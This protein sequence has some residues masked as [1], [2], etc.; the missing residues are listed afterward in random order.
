MTQDRPD[1][2][3]AAAARDP[4]AHDVRANDRSYPSPPHENQPNEHRP[5]EH[6]PDE[7]PPAEN[8]PNVHRPAENQPNEHRPAENPPAEHP[9]A[10]HP[11]DENQ[12]NE[13]LP[14]PRH[15]E[16]GTL[17]LAA[18]P[19]GNPADA[20]ARLRRE[21]ATADVIAAEDTR[22]LA[23]L[24]ADLG[25]QPG[26]RVV[27]YHDHNE[28][29]RTG[30]LVQELTI[31]RRVLLVTDAGMPSAS[32]P[33]YRL[34]TA[35]IAAGVPVTCLPGPSAITAALAVSGLPTDRFCFEGF[36]PRK[37]AERR[38]AIAALAAEPR[39]L[40]FFEAPHR[41]AQT[42]ADL[43]Q[44]FG[45]QRPAALC[46]ELTKTYEEIRRAGLGELAAQAAAEPVRGEITLVVGGAVAVP[47]SV[48][49]AL[50]RVREL[51]A[52]G[53]RLKDA[54]RA[55]AEDAAVSSRELYARALAEAQQPT[56]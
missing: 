19:L 48:D 9:P 50:Q 2:A 53:V 46:R 33:G 52:Q 38:R 8:Q 16:L 3:V 15:G 56:T 13:H 5:N 26:G 54:C 30:P 45:P 47:M 36:P 34:V 40:V 55:A 41:I 24:C 27:S 18:T 42:L 22:R 10:E 7:N 43:A 23:R 17:V 14:N 21:L 29:A 39:T 37:P 20:S 6:R 31:G 44:A 49:Q 12:P 32:D 25:V 11:P 51:R 28:A 4:D 35:A 1:S